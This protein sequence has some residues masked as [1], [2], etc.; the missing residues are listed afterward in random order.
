METQ[1]FNHAEGDIYNILITPSS[2]H[3]NYTLVVM[4]SAMLNCKKCCR[5][6]IMQAD[7]T[8]EQKKACEGFISE[9]PGNKVD[10][11]NVDINIFSSY[12]CF[13][14]WHGHYATNFKLLAHN[15][16]PDDI[17]RVAYL[18]T[19]TLV[20][21]DIA[22]LYDIDFE[23]TF[24]HA[25]I[26][27]DVIQDKYEDF[28]KKEDKGR[29]WPDY[30]TIGGNLLNV[31]KFRENKITPEFYDEAAKKAGYPMAYAEQSTLAY[32]FWDKVKLYPF[33]YYNFYLGCYKQYRRIMEI[34]NT[35]TAQERAADYHSVYTEDFDEN[36]FASIVHYTG[37]VPKPWQ[38]VVKNGILMDSGTPLTMGSGYDVALEPFY[39]E[40]WETAKKLPQK[41][42]EELASN[43][44]D[45]YHKYSIEAYQ[46]LLKRKTNAEV[47]FEALALDYNGS[48]NFDN[49]IRN[50][51]S[52]KISILNDDSEVGKF[53]TKIAEQNGIDIVFRTGTASMPRLEAR[54]WEKCKSADVI[55]C[56]YVHGGA[57]L[58]RENING[59]L[60]SDIIKGS[61]LPT[62]TKN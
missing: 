25:P 58:K 23:D 29:Y 5:F 39:I 7:W 46:I 53:F 62:E 21:K 40:W 16:L 26:H 9:Y 47:F 50:I 41:Y 51:K 44:L 2:M 33:Y 43:A 14:Q 49:F 61:P 22:P 24:L 54:D 17:E 11:I 60:L 12:E 4:L 42:Y 38:T 52:K 28:A 45:E 32:L 18:D 15:Y 34:Y 19:D 35:T 48:H 57:I 56:C 1:N 6:F 55:V 20:R 3:F 36:K 27:Q 59:I 30:F 10:F 8:D 13:Q 37:G 31:K